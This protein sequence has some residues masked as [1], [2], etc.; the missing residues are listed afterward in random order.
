MEFS[1]YVCYIID[2]IKNLFHHKKKILSLDEILT[3][4]QKIDMDQS[5]IDLFQ[6]LSDTEEGVTSQEII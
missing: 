4:K 6:E 1:L 5:V 3:E 2:S